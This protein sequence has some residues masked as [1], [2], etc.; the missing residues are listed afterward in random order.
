MHYI[1]FLKAPRV[2]PALSSKDRLCVVTKIAITSDLGEAFLTAD[3]PLLVEIESS[4]SA[5]GTDQVPKRYGKAVARPREVQWKGSV[6]MRALDVRIE[7]SSEEKAYFAGGCVRLCVRARDDEFDAGSLIGHLCPPSSN[8]GSRDEIRG[9]VLAVR[10]MDFNLDP[11]SSEGVQ[12]SLG[13]KL[14]ER[15]LA[16]EGQELH[17]WEELGESI[18]RHIWDAG[19]VLSSY[20]ASIKVAPVPQRMKTLE[21]ILG[22]EGL[23]VLELGAGCGIVGIAL[24]TYFPNSASVV[25]TDLPEA[26]E[27]LEHN[28]SVAT[29]KSSTLATKLSTQ[30]LDWSSPLP[31]DIR[32]ESKIWDLII[33]ADCTYN[34]DVV[35]DLVST[36]S[37]IGKCNPQVVVLLAMKVRHESEMVFFELM[38]EKGFE[39]RE[40][41]GVPV[42]LLG[43]DVEERIEIYLFGAVGS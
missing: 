17:I 12:T 2:D 34:P 42:P 43:L 14:S 30:D 26:A 10:S 28:L 27:I 5:S 20:L 21:A 1:R 37:A 33:V 40:N 22:K 32:S 9:K 7:L 16:A 25:L 23:C 19:L 39:I 31:E 38:K 29:T 36:L 11:K 4:P 24:A 15:R 18:A 8:S 6:G 3:L 13:P 35:P 41:V